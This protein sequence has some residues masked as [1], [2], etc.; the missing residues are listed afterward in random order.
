MTTYT[1]NRV[2]KERSSDQ[3][4]LHIEGVITTAGVDYTRR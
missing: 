1:V 3:S 4:Q 2:R